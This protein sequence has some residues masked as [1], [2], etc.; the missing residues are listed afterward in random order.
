MSAALSITATDAVT[1]QINRLEAGLRNTALLHGYIAKEALSLTRRHLLQIGATRHATAQRLGAA[2]TGHWAKPDDYTTETSDSGAAIVTIAKAGIGRA[3]HDV[4]ITPGP[5]KKFL[6]LPNRREAYGRRAAGMIGET[7][8]VW[9]KNGPWAIVPKG[10][11]I[12]S[13]WNS[14]SAAEVKTAALY[15]LCKM[16]RQKRDRTLLP[17]DEAY[18]HAAVLA[19]TQY[20]DDTLKAKGVTA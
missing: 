18:R 16:V 9:G 15:L 14:S 12:P 6:A 8:F 7:K 3:A 13:P 20:V 10:F 11:K 17:P 19:A 2:P 4:T 5:G 1:P